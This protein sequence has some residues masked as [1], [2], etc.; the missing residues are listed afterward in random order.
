[1]EWGICI[2]AGLYCKH[3]VSWEHWTV[4][5]LRNLHDMYTI[6]GAHLSFNFLGQLAVATLDIKASLDKIIK[7]KI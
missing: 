2:A 5:N 1:M 7:T 3:P 6:D 4:D